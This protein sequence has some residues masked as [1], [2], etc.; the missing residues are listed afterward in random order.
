MSGSIADLRKSIKGS[1]CE[2]GDQGY[3]LHK[4][5]PY[6]TKPSKIIITPEEIDDISKAIKASFA[7]SQGLP[8]AIRGGGHSTS[9]AS[10]TEGL[11]I[12]MRRMNK[13]RVDEQNRIGYIQ[14]G[15]RTHDIEVEL[16][17]YGLAACVGACSQVSIG[18]YTLGGG[19]GY[20]TGAYGLAA[21]NMVSATV[22]LATGEIVQASD[23]ENPDLLWAL[24][25]AGSNFGVVAELGVKLHPQ[26]P[27]VYSIS[28]VYL[29]SQLPVVVD[30][31]NEWLKVQ[32]DNEAFQFGFSLGMDGSPYAMITGI[33]NSTQEEGETAYKC[34]VDLGPVHTTCAQIPYDKVSTQADLYN[35][36]PGGK[37]TVGAHIDKFD[38]AQVQKSWDAWSELIKKAPQSLVMYEFYPYGKIASVPLEHGA[39]AQRHSFITVLCL[40]IWTDDNFTPYIRNELLKVRR[41]VSRSSCEAAQ[42]SLGYPNY[43]NLFA[44]LNETDEY[45]R[46]LFGP[47]YPRLQELKKKYD[48]DMVFDRWFAIR[49]AP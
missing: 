46:K 21:D 11:L 33:S 2:P 38:L 34:F 4:W 5:S 18:G 47:N 6:S 16:I 31:I 48:P 20:S 40:A 26:R 7:R 23:S 30:A 39:F 15:A 27:D 49:P 1:V 45:A 35:E 14:A 32:K 17:K 19:L 22:V 12:D 36:I 8:F 37:D 28:Y 44:T 9:T 13:I 29:P 41:V 10:A 25:G 3:D 24:R 43:A 42:E